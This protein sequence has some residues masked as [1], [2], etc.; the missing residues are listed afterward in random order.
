MW[1]RWFRMQYEKY[2]SY[3]KGPQAPPK[4]NQSQTELAPMKRSELI[5]VGIVLKGLFKLSPKEDR[6]LDKILFRVDQIWQRS[7]SKFCIQYLSEALRLVMV[8][9]AGKG[10]GPAMRISCYPSG[11]PRIVGPFFRDIILNFKNF[12]NDKTNEGP[13]TRILMRLITSCLA[14]FRAMSFMSITKFDS[15]T[16][17]FTGTDLSLSEIEDALRELKLSRGSLQI[18]KPRILWSTRTGVTPDLGS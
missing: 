7:G 17:K 15:V 3:T 1:F 11:I 8:V 14:I 5:R 18:G 10:V 2:Y 16:D 9:L 12:M 13:R 6:E 4:V